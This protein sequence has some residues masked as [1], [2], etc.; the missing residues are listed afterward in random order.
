MKH[1][2]ELHDEFGGKSVLRGDTGFS[3][4]NTLMNE[5]LEDVVKNYH[6]LCSKGITLF[7][8]PK[9]DAL[10]EADAMWVGQELGFVVNKHRNEQGYHNISLGAKADIEMNPFKLKQLH[11]FCKKISD[12][13]GI[14]IGRFDI[15]MTPTGLKLL[16]LSI[17]NVSKFS[18]MSDENER[19]CIDYFKRAFLFLF[20]K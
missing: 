11:D 2:L 3:G 14:Y 4:V 1:A 5:N 17:P 6:T 13:F 19:L 20:E 12:C 15:L 9:E 10:I 16:E 8:S 7:I 18:L